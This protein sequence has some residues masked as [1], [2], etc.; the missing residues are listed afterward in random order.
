MLPTPL[1]SNPQVTNGANS[2]VG[3][4][5]T[6]TFQLGPGTNPANSVF[7]TGTAGAPPPS[8]TTDGSGAASGTQVG[9]GKVNGPPISG[10]PT[11]QTLLGGEISTTT[12]PTSN[13]P[14][15]TNAVTGTSNR[16]HS[17]L[18]SGGVAGIIAVLA[19]FFLAVFLIILRRR[20]AA[21]AERHDEMPDVF[22]NSPPSPQQRESG[23]VR[24]SPGGPQDNYQNHT[25]TTQPSSDRQMDA[26]PGY[27]LQRG[28]SPLAMAE[29]DERPRPVPTLVLRNER[30]RRHNHRLSVVTEIPNDSRRYSGARHRDTRRDDA[31]PI[32][33]HSSDASA[34]RT[35]PSTLRG[36][37]MSPT[38]SQTSLQA[39]PSPRTPTRGSAVIPP[40]PPLPKSPPPIP[41]VH[42]NPFVDRNPFA[43]PAG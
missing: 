37:G 18:T 38:S 32:S 9:A 23:I 25:P 39:P 33:P 21:R 30:F 6:V 35:A 28:P 15:Q 42:A 14:S 26:Y 7:M 24:L 31:S 2:N 5:G 1:S 17:G 12:I 10:D 27:T 41:G 43:D 19:I 3:S 40:I 20:K 36:S 22:A 11:T 8:V 34:F 29:I 16:S 4:G 13:S